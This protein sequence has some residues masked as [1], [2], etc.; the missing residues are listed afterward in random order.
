MNYTTAMEYIESLKQYGCVPG[1]E[2]M[3]R[4]CEKLNNPQASL[5][6]VHIAGTNGKG[7]VL[8]YISTILQAAGYRVG[9]YSSPA[10]FS[11][12]EMFQVNSRPITQSGF[13]KYLEQARAAASLIVSEGFPHPTEFEMETAV[14]FLYFLDQKC[15]IVVMEAGMGG[16]LD[17]TNIVENTLCAVFS[18]ISM[19]H[20]A[21][22]GNTLEEI[23]AQKAGIIKSR[24]CVVSVRQQ[25]AA[26]QVLKQEA[27]RKKCRMLIADVSRAKNVVYG[28]DR[29]IFTYDKY[30]DLEIRMTGTVQIENAALAVETITALQKC[31]FPV[32]EEKLRLG[33]SCAYWPGRFQCLAGQPMFVL[34]GAHNE[35]AAI[36]LA[37]GIRQYFPEKRIL[38]I[39]G[40]LR[41][42]EYEKIIEQTCML[43]EAII[44]VT[45]PH[46]LRALS[47][48]ELAQAVLG[49]HE[50][51][52]VADSLEEA[53]EMAR[54]LAGD[55]PDTIV[56]AFGSLS[57][58]G[59][60]AE[61]IL[62][63]NDQKE[64]TGR[65]N[66]HGSGEN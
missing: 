18:S 42:K 45:P 19:D 43:A 64:E 17:A 39:M 7:S 24:S 32:P 12:R 49:Y 27:S 30:K 21:M 44:T 35:D 28:L 40:V 34:D 54:L 47:G 15:D 61:I 6:F 16:S 37:E 50:H 2:S 10:V 9:S 62:R 65:V 25:P 5:T 55:D 23:A 63:I 36:R 48:Y 51:V 26:M 13:C 22:L 60:L 11:F 46:N 14:A 38:Y 29:Q 41:D 66:E 56:V 20:M 1:L 53:V 33:L 57:Y 8:A 52:T 3:Q 4:L 59:E 58:L 31:G